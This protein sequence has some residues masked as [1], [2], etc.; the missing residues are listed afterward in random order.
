MNF[1]IIAGVLL[2]GILLFGCTSKMVECG[3]SYCDTSIETQD[4][5]CSDC[6]CSSRYTCQNNVCVELV[7]DIKV[8]S[9]NIS[10]QSA[11][12]LRSIG[13]SLD[14]CIK[15]EGNHL[16]KNIK[17][18]VS[19]PS[20]YFGDVVIDGKS[21]GINESNCYG[22]KLSFYDSVLSIVSPTQVQGSITGSYINSIGKQFE[23]KDS[24]TFNIN[25][26]NYYTGGYD[27][28]SSISL[29]ITPD[30]PSIRQFASRSTGGLA[31]Y[32][33]SIEQLLAAK[34]IFANMRTYGVKYTS[35]A[36]VSADYFEFPYDTLKNK[37]GDCEDNAILFAS[38]LEAIG[39][40]SVIVIVPGH[41]YSG[42]VNKE[43][44]IVPVETTA[45][46]SDQ[47]F[48]ATIPQDAIIIY[49]SKEWSNYPQ[50]IIPETSELPM[51]AISKQKGDCEINWNFQ[52][53][54][55]VSAPI[56]YTN[57]GNAPGAGC[58]ALIVVD[59]KN[60]LLGSDLKCLLVNPGQ[61]IDIDYIYDITMSDT[62]GASCL[63]I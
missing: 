38:M 40:T 19:S 30:Q 47:M 16:A 13:N 5:C 36:H 49:P 41:A 56:R 55:Y 39:M 53:G 58:T 42:Y 12:Q 62:S 33:S 31:T 7:P 44:N 17:I 4:N 1:K 28:I 61:T 60:K 24:F 27:N 18:E 35:D 8:I 15:N 25:G 48:Q 52:D 51:P 29:Y 43:G 34:W 45:A 46:T 23:I 37:G 50:V 10:T 59:N 21:L 20:N 2:I 3:D 14:I 63:V 9:T 57:T 54:Y 32:S 11:A 26:K 22:A 6:N